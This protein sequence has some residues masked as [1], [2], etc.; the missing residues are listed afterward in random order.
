M[1]RAFEYRKARKMKRWAN[2]AKTFTRIT[3]E[4]VM[5]VK[6]S[7]PDPD[8]NPRLKAAIQNA[9]AANMPKDNVT[10]AIKRAT[11]KDTSNYDFKVFEGYAPHGIAVLI[12]T[13]SDN[14]NRTVADIRSYFTK[15]GGSL[16]VS[17]SVEFMFEHKCFFKIANEGQD[18]EELELEMIDYG[19]DEI[20]EDEEENQIILYAPFEE[21]GKVHSALND[22]EM[23]ILSSG[24]ER[25][26]M[27]TKELSEEDQADVQKLLDKLEENEDVTNYY[28]T[29]QEGEE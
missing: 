15:V 7:G 29:M 3:K 8:A 24:T 28:H 19:V 13:L 2:M 22:K 9:K 10:R 20:V 1:G 6:E 21:Y 12:E 11:D 23:E 17:G 4:I 27:D 26:A 18:I 5:A 25:F 16:G 14:N